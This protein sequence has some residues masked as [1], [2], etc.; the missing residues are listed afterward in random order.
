[1]ISTHGHTTVAS[2][3]SMSERQSLSGLGSK[4]K[5]IEESVFNYFHRESTADT[6]PA[7]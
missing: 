2:K 5:H 3:T 6:T 4:A 7:I 1:M